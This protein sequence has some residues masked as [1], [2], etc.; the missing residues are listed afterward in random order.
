MGSGEAGEATERRTPGAPARYP[1]A[2]TLTPLHGAALAVLL[3]APSCADPAPAP[4]PTDSASTSGPELP[5][6]T[7]DVRG[8]TRA[9]ATI[10]PVGRGR[11][12]GTVRLIQAAGGV[13]VL[14]EIDGLSQT[15]YHGFQILRGRDCSADPSVHLGAEA[16][17]PHGSPY[18][19]PGDRHA[20]DLGNVRGDGGEGRYDRI[21]PVLRL[22]GTRSALG[23]AVVLRAQRDD[24][25][26]PDGA[27]GDVIG[28]GVLEPGA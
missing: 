13:R 20:G 12:T 18:A 2:M 26:S 21:D 3:A 24:A 8:I 17:T 10:E 9:T 23:R 14:A 11:A 25:A 7:V 1:R 4:L 6:D 15:G 27:A 16:G 22:E 19:L 28:C 5:P